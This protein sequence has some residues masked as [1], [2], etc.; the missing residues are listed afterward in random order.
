MDGDGDDDDEN[1]RNLC[2][3]NYPCHDNCLC[4]YH[5]QIHGVSVVA[6][7]QTAEAAVQFFPQVVV[8]DGHEL[9]DG[10]EA[11][12]AVLVATVAQ[13][14]EAKVAALAW[15]AEVELLAC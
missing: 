11:V 8:A 4:F 1:L 2:A 7:E 5:G 9:A 12:G 10:K 14:C 13:L 3:D 15:V 6:V